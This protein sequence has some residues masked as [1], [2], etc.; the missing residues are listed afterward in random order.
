[1]SVITHRPLT[2]D[3]ISQYERD[4]YLVFPDM[5]TGDEI[6]AFLE[7]FDRVKEKAMHYNL[8]G[9]VKDLQ[10]KHL[11]HHPNQAGGAS[12]I[13]GGPVR[14]V[15]TMFMSKAAKGGR[16]VAMHQDTHYLPTEPNTLLACWIALTDTDPENGGLCVVPGSH[17]R[18]LRASAKN[19]D[20][21]QH[22]TWETIYDMRDRNGRE[23]KQPMHSFVIPDLDPASIVRLTVPRGAGVFFTGMTI[24]GSFANT[25]PDRPRRAFATHYVKE[26]TWVYRRDVQET[27]PVSLI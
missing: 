7:N 6:S 17:K 24:H 16:G 9:H 15:Q 12:Q 20:D 2:A 19:A 23:W 22:D 21:S 10:Y 14:V 1:M 8:H 3:Q 4:G 25:S 5:L 11:A 27:D 26:G 13:V 18:G